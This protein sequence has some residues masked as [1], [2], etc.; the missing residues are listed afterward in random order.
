M[1]RGIRRSIENFLY[2]T[3]EKVSF[4]VWEVV[5]LTMDMGLKWFVREK[6]TKTPK[7]VMAEAL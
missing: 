6:E 5:N 4:H 1:K 2:L 3:M 7:Y